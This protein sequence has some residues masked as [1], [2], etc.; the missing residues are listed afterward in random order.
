MHACRIRV[1]KCSQLDS[2]CKIKNCADADT[3]IILQLEIQG[4]EIMCT[5]EYVADYK[6]AG[7]AQLL[8]L[9]KPWTG[10]GEPVVLIRHSS[11]LQQC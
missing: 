1:L 2:S 10:V 7:I 6:L 9:T 8:R 11:A 5:K 4:D 3:K